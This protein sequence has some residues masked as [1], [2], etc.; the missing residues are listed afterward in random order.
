[1]SVSMER[2]TI[3]LHEACYQGRLDVVARLLAEGANPNE[4][5]DAT[6]REW[7]SCAGG[8]PRPLNCVA[9]AWDMTECHL[10]IARLLIQYGGIVDDSVIRDHTIEMCGGPN[11]GVFR[12]I[13]EAARRVSR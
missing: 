6:E 7:V 3:S 5:A 12:E 2:S 1:M 10:Q 11:D 9:I 13:L 4:P 8:R